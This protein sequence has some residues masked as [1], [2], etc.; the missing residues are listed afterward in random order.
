[1]YAVAYATNV[2]GRFLLSRTSASVGDPEVRDTNWCLI[3][4]PPRA[5]CS[6]CFLFLHFGDLAGLTLSGC[7]EVLLVGCCSAGGA[8]SHVVNGVVMP[9]DQIMWASQ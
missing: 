4:T 3:I 2:V 6:F 7:I 8:A 1:M 5:R 9:A